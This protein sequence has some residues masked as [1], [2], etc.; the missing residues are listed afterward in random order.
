[1]LYF[2]LLTLLN[3]PAPPPLPV[4]V[5]PNIVRVGSVRFRLVKDTDVRLDGT[6][7]DFDRIDK[8]ATEIDVIEV[9]ADKMTLLKLYFKSKP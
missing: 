1:M 4:Q 5:E 9:A 3:L 7:T 6:P 8:A 2:L